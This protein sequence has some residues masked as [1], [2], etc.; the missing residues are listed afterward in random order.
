MRRVHIIGIGSPFGDDRIG[1]EAVD[2]IDKSGILGRF[3]PGMV[4]TFCCNQPAVG[5]LPLLSGAGAAILID[6][7][8]GKEAPGTLRKVDVDTL[9][10][11][12]APLSSHGLSVSDSLAL[13]RAVGM[14]PETVLVYGIEIGE[15]DA[16]P[17]A[18]ARIRAA[19]PAL[20]REIAADL[21][22]LFQKQFRQDAPCP[23][24]TDSMSSSQ[25]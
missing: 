22:T 9:Q 21:Q 10:P 13:G 20:L 14:L 7:L 11:Q 16:A 15:S 3:P 23:H 17:G 19:I 1:W 2:A 6:A 25:L 18:S 5:L 4:K 8:R 24:S 12:S